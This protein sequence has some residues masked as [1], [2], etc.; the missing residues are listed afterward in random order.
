VS[1]LSDTDNPPFGAAPVSVTV[2]WE[3][4]PPGTLEG[5][6]ENEFRTGGM[7]ASIAV[8]VPPKLAEIVTWVEI[9]TGYVVIKNVALVLPAGTVTV[10]GTP[11]AVGVSLPS[12]IDSPPVGAAPVS[13]TVP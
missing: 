11:A 8:I 4:T 9:A 5:L 13:V 6:M 1:L 12:D 3:T 7:T 2:P 10:A